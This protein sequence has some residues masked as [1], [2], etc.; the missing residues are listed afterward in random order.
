MFYLFSKT[1]IDVYVSLWFYDTIWKCT[2]RTTF[3]YSTIF[4][5]ASSNNILNFF[6]APCLHTMK[7]PNMTIQVC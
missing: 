4:W 6:G 5:I 2:H 7:I 3:H 1:Y